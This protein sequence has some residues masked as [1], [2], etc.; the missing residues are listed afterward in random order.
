ML[1]HPIL[2][3]WEP[4]MIERIST[5]ETRRCAILS[6]PGLDG[7][8]RQDLGRNGLAVEIRGSLQGDD[9]RDD[10]LK[11]VR[12]K[13]AAGSP[14]DFVA[15]IVKESKLERVVIEELEF[16]EVAG[17]P[18]SFRYRVVLR[19][20]TEPPAPPAPSADFGLEL[21]PDLD[22]LASLGLDALDLPA[23]AASVPNVGDLLAPLKP[24]AANLKT[25][26]GGAG[27]LLQP[28]TDLLS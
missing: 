1:V 7:D 15:D 3:S 8:L 2:D 14:V 25:A 17:S 19:E 22:A 27:S 10:L 26:L 13:F 9:A 6:V 21:D 23:I 28:L 5:I 20:Y 4:P 11:Q 16:S 24:A 12:E 18:D